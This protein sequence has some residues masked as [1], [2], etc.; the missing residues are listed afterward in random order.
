MKHRTAPSPVGEG[1]VGAANKPRSDNTPQPFT[2]TPATLYV[3][4]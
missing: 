2:Y 3:K 1:G 4:P